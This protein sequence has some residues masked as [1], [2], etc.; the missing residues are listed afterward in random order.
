LCLTLCR[1]NVLHLN[2][3]NLINSISCSSSSCSCMC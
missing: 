1:G 2:N 3:M